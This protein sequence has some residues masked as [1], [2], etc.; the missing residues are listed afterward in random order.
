MLVFLEVD[1][2]F[3]LE[4][5]DVVLHRPFLRLVPVAVMYIVAELLHSS[6]E[7]KSLLE[8]DVVFT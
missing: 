6:P 8:L 2:L 4:Q 7:F 5:C 1:W 3:Q